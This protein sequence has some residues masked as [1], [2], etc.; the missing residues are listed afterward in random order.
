MTSRSASASALVS[1]AKSGRPL[2]AAAASSSASGTRRRRSNL[3][4]GRLVGRKQGERAA[5]S[6]LHRSGPLQVT[7][8]S[9]ACNVGE[10]DSGLTVLA[11]GQHALDAYPV[12]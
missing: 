5:G 6:G 4:V 10:H 11:Y 1:A 9:C 7:A 12:A 8:I 2:R 3:H